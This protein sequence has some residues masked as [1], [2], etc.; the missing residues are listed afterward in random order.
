MEG[1]STI[2][3][4]ISRCTQEQSKAWN[5]RV[6]P[7]GISPRSMR[8]KPVII[9]IMIFCLYI[10][11]FTYIG[12]NEIQGG[13]SLP[14]TNMTSHKLKEEDDPSLLECAILRASVSRWMAIRE[15]MEV[16]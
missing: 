4:G 15:D 11:K 12:V 1:K 3:V 5:V 10:Y 7:E 14:P 6:N 16:S 2:I 13:F 9:G 8:M